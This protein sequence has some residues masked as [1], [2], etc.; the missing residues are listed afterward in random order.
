MTRPSVKNRGDSLANHLSVKR[1]CQDLLA[2]VPDAAEKPVRTVDGVVRPLRLLLRRGDKERV[3]ALRVGAVL[4]D[5]FVGCDNV[6]VRFRHLA[7]L[8]DEWLARLAM[9]RWA[10]KD[11][12]F[13]S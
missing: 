6:E 9:N 12:R 10:E 7:R 5:E 11:L 2:H 8:G 13:F 3:D 1:R 4:F